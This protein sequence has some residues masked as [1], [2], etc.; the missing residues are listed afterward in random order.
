[1]L[2]PPPD[3]PISS[4]T[5]SVALA[6][7]ASSQLGQGVVRRIWLNSEGLL[8]LNHGLDT[9]VHVLDEVLLGAAQSALVGDVEGA[10]VGLG[11][12]T[13][14]ASDL[15]VELVG[16]LLEL[17]HVLGELGELDVDGG[18]ESG[19]EV[20]GARGDVAEVVIM[21]ELADGLDVSGGAAE[22]VE[23]RVEV[24]TVLHG[25]DTELILFIDPHEEGLGIVVEDTS[26]LGP[27]AVK[28]ACL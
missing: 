4:L 14:D 2:S 20:G 26:A 11:V 3:L 10:V 21:G 28:T 22:S 1:M 9:V 16:D 6:E 23:D 24:G 13:V 7:S 19:S 18:A 25:D 15:D 17:F 8:L 12:L 5:H 27:F